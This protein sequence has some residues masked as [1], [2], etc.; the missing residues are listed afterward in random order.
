MPKQDDMN[1]PGMVRQ[2]FK[3]R[4]LDGDLILIQL[5]VEHG[6]YKKVAEV[7]ADKYELDV[8]PTTVRYHAQRLNLQLRFVYRRWFDKHQDDMIEYHRRDL[9]RED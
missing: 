8:L 1:M 9:I 7:L 6:S 4:D 2:H 5:L 3:D